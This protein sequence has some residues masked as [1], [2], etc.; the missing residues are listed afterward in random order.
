MMGRIYAIALNTFREAIRKKVIYGIV[1]AV[2][3]VYGFAGVLDSCSLHEEE[4]IGRDVGLFGVSVLGSITAIVLGVALLYT[5]VERR[6]IHVILAKPIR[7]PEFVLGKYLGMATTLT[8]LTFAF[9]AVMV[10]I[11]PLTG[12]AVKAVLLAWTEVLVVAGIAIFFSSF[13]SPFLS[14]FFTAAI[15]VAG[16]WYHELE[17]AAEK[18]R[19]AVLKGAARVIVWIL[20]DLHL[21]SVSGGE[22]GGQHVTVHGSFVGWGYVASAALY[23]VLVIAILLALAIVIFRR[24]DFA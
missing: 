24:R 10:V 15:W 3:V 12:N 2:V 19:V 9:A 22:V 13:A 1:V 4:R 8:V 7:R 6:T 17:S 14:G 18:S 20:P 16:R 21:Y 23:G 11:T 5:E